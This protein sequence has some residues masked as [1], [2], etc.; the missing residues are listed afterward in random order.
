L[1]D[2]I[3]LFRR[4]VK[5]WYAKN[6]RDFYWRREKLSPYEVLILEIMLQKTRAEKVEEIFPGF[7]SKYVCPKTLAFTPIEELER[8]L[9]PLGLYKR[10]ASLIKRTA[11]LICTRFGG[12]IPKDYNSLLELPGVGQYIASA[13]LCF[14]FGEKIIPVD[15]NVKRLLE[16]VFNVEVK[17]IRR[18]DNRVSNFLSAIL[19]NEEDVKDLVWAI[20]DFAALVCK[21]RDPNHEKCPIREICNYYFNF[22]ASK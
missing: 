20:L 9:L 15:V 5:T 8:D 12:E 16:R 11:E 18:L 21:K 1:S 19:A 22:V 3:D 17:N 13:V 10:R 7:V 6:R 2:S 4:G 14:G